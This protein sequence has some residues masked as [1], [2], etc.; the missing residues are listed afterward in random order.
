[1]ANL[2]DTTEFIDY[3]KHYN[4]AHVIY[5][6][7]DE[8]DNDVTTSVIVEAP[9]IAFSTGGF[10]RKVKLVSVTQIPEDVEDIEVY[11]AQLGSEELIRSRP[12]DVYDGEI[13]KNAT[14]VYEEDYYLGDIIEV[15][16]SN[17]GTAYMRAVEQIFKSD[18][19]GESAYPSLVS[20][21]SITPGT[22]ASWKYDVDWVDMGS[23]EYWSTQ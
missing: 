1:M 8:F 17:G 4:V 15:R 22:W 10:Q 14:Y 20:K 19:T 11:L 3:S 16:G 21:T 12:T 5:F 6:H 23:D 7:K 18:N 13:A 2:I 9:E